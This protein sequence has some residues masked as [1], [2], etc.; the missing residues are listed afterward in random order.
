VHPPSGDAVL[1]QHGL[2]AAGAQRHCRLSAGSDQRE[3][4]GS[5][6]VS[7][8]ARKP[9]HGESRLN[10]QCKQ[11]PTDCPQKIIRFVIMRTSEQPDSSPC[12]EEHLALMACVADARGLLQVWE[13]AVQLRA[14]H[15]LLRGVPEHGRIAAHEGDA[16]EAVRGG[17]QCPGSP[18]ARL[19]P[20]LTL[21][22]VWPVPATVA[23]A[24]G[25]F[26]HINLALVH[27]LAQIHE[28]TF[29]YP[30]RLIA[31]VE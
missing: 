22:T 15:S 14:R 23:R 12:R 16:C 2:L 1:Q 21:S 4:S 18:G 24:C 26:A 11:Q 30:W 20:R 6:L 3:G 7:M 28:E 5:I 19:P 9:I 10:V 31:T 8:P 13:G 17:P 25:W 29:R 27:E